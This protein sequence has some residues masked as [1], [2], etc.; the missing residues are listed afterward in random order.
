MYCS[1][2]SACCC[3]VNV[4]ALAPVPVVNCAKLISD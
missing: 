3:A 2:A 1:N 4:R